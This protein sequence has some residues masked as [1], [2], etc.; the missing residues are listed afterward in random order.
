V[1]LLAHTKREEITD[2]DGIVIEKTVPELPD[3]YLGTMVEWSDFVCLAKKIDEDNRV[4][5][6]AETPRAMAKNRYHLP[7]SIPFNW[8]SFTGAIATGL[9]ENFNNP[10][11]QEK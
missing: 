6:T 4:L 9:S 11:T 3:G 1:I 10:K 8:Q 7:E 5:I 2:V